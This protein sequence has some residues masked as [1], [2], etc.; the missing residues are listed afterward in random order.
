[1]KQRSQHILA[2]LIFLILCSGKSFAT[3]SESLP[4]FKLDTYSTRVDF[5]TE[6]APNLG[7]GDD[8]LLV[9]RITI[10][11]TTKEEVGNIL[12]F[13]SLGHRIE[14]PKI[15]SNNLSYNISQLEPGFYFIIIG[16]HV[17]Q[18]QKL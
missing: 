6:E 15:E 16:Q 17:L 3:S 13:D 10:S 7:N 5:N 12:I 9:N 8:D 18:F 1:M 2:V 14:L 11:G 4:H